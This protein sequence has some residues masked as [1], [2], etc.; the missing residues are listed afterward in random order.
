MRPIRI[1]ALFLLIQWH[2]VLAQD[3][4][5]ILEIRTAFNEWQTWLEDTKIEPKVY[6]HSIAEN[7]DPTGIW[8]TFQPGDSVTVTEVAHV[9]SRPHGGHLVK[10]NTNS[11]SGDWVIKTENYYHGNGDLFFI[12]WTMNTFQADIPVIVEKRLYFD[13]RTRLIK[14]LQTVYEMNTKKVVDAGFADREVTI[15]STLNDIGFLK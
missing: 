11:I 6:Y 9:F 10:V 4:R 1:I 5:K 12:F 14:Q 15:W 2:S 7:N 13:G 8:T 3:D